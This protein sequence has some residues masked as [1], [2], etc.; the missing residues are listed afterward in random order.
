M[1]EIDVKIVRLEPMRVISAYGFGSQPEPIAWEKILDFA[2]EKG[3][4]S[5]GELPQ[6]FGFNNPNPSKGSSNY[7]YEIWLPVSAEVE[8][9]GDLRVVMFGGGL[10]AATHFKDLNKIGGVWHQLAKW[11]E[12]SKYKTAHHQWLEE[13]TLASDDIAELEFNLYLPIVE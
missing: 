5:R 9:E 4:I 13:Q 11:R 1:S 6:T 8:P 12:G 3:L 7:G 2:K 10:Y